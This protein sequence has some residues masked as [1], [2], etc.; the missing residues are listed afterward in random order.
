MKSKFAV[1]ALVLA[2]AIIRFANIATAQSATGFPGNEAV[3][4]VA[5]K[6]V[7]EVPPTPRSSSKPKPEDYRPPTHRGNNGPEVVMIEGPDGL[8]A[9]SDHVLI[10]TACIPSDIGT[11]KRP[12]IWL[13]KL[14]GKWQRCNSRVAPIECKPLIGIGMTPGDWLLAPSKS[15]VE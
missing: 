3:R 14:S 10:E 8:M 7:V 6:R 13:V 2:A 4:I 9:C 12:R 15:G 1:P 5:G 11:V